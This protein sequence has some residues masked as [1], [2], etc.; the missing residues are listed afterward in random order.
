MSEANRVSLKYLAEV[1]YGDTPP[2]SNSW[3]LLRY[4]SQSIAANP[5]TVVS[6]EIRD[7]R[8]VTDLVLV[9][10]SVSGDMGCEFSATT[11]DELLEAA[12]MG[13]WT[14]G[15]LKASTDEYS[16]S[17]EV[18]FEDW[19]P[20]QYLQYKGMRVGGFSLNIAY[21]SI[22]TGSFSFAG[23]QA[24]ESITS[25]RG[26][27]TAPLPQTNTD[28]FN[29]SSGV[30]TI[31]VDGTSFSVRSL[32][33]NLSNNLRPVEAIGAAGP[34]D[35]SAGRSMVT[36]T[37]E[38]YFDDISMYQEL[39]TPTGVPVVFALTDGTNTY[40]FTLP[41]VKFNDGN[42][43]V[44]GVDTDVMLSMNFTALYD[45]TDDTNIKLVKS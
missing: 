20:V 43:A 14:G 10:S 9:G 33:L 23:K 22:V 29:G 34:T 26:T 42:P 40:T 44:T 6:N 17:L 12:F 28:V 21:G 3:Q 18:G 45:A 4:T 39:L 8:M 1:T 13:T 16:F 11:Y 30:T 19:S 5:Q 25:L 35:Q 15:T 31:T 27:G 36:G 37:I 7:D 32:T 2:N 41:K 24:L 38:I